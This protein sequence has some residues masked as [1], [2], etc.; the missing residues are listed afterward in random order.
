[1]LYDAVFRF[2][3]KSAREADEL[4]LAIDRLVEMADA[5]FDWPEPIDAQLVLV[6]PSPTIKPYFEG[7]ANL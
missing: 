5:E 4:A 7:K 2:S 6:S 3:A 1:M